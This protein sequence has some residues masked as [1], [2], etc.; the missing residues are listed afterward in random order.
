MFSFD[1]RDSVYLFSHRALLDIFPR[2][3]YAKYLGNLLS[4]VRLGEFRCSS[5]VCICMGIYPSCHCRLP[6]FHLLQLLERTHSEYGHPKADKIF[7]FMVGNLY[8]A[9]FDVYG[10]QSFRICNILIK[11]NCT[12]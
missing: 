10:K 4:V 9:W 8:S 6:I 1:F 3:G 7:C 2:D 12:Q 5:N 11:W